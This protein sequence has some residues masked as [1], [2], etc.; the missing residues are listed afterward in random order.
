MGIIMFLQKLKRNIVV[1]FTVS[2]ECEQYMEGILHNDYLSPSYPQQDE[3]LSM[4]CGKSAADFTRQHALTSF[5]T[6]LSR[7][8]SVPTSL[9]FL[10]FIR[11]LSLGSVADESHIDF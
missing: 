4:L 8:W 11:R 9:K 10:L 6:V 7:N 1:T 3:I 2:D 5:S